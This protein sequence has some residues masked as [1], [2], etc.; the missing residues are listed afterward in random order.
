M[1]ELNGISDVVMHPAANRAINS[2]IADL[3]LRTPRPEIE[4]WLASYRT[5]ILEVT[6]AGSRH[7]CS[8]DI[9][10]CGTPA[11]PAVTSLPR[12]SAVRA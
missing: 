3:A 2:Y 7:F 10:S 6:K 11:W 12:V 5:E 9:A 4:A 8:R 1:F